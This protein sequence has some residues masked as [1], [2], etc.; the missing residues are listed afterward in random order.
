VQIPPSSAVALTVGSNTFGACID[1]TGGVS[2]VVALAGGT[3]LFTGF[4]GGGGGGGGAGGAVNILDFGGTNEAAVNASHQLAIQAPP[5]LPLPSNAAQET[6]GNLATV[7]TNTGTTATNTTTTNTDLGPPGATA[8]TT[9]TAS[10]SINQQMQRLAQRLSTLITA[11][12]SPVQAGTVP[13]SAADGQLATI[14]NK[15]DAKSS[16]TDGTSISVQQVLKE[17]SF[18]LQNP[19]VVT[20]TFWQTT[21]PVSGTVTANLGTLNG[22]ATAANQSSVI[23]SSTG[24]T[25]AASSSLAGAI[26]NSSPPSLTTGQ[27]VGLQTDSAGRLIVNVAAGGGTGGTSSNFASAFPS[28]G[29][30]IGAKNGAN[31]VN[32]TADSS[33]NL[34]VNCTVGCAGGTFNNNADGVATSTTNGQSAGWNYVFNGTTWDRLRGDTTNGLFADVKTIAT[35]AAVSGAFVDGAIATIGTKADAAWT[36]GAGSEIS[37]L[38]TIAAGVINTIDEGAF[39]FGTTVNL[40]AACVFQTTPTS[41]ALTTGQMGAVQ[42]TSNR[43]LFTNAY[44]WAGGVL[45]AMANYGTSPGAVLVPGVNA[46]VTNTIAATVSGVSTAANQPSN[47]AIG[48]TTSGQTGNLEMGAVTTAAPTYTTAQTNPLSLTT[49]GGLRT[50]ESTVAGTTISTGAGATGTGTQRVGIAQ[51]TTTIAGSAPGT[52]GSAS[53][54]VVT[55][56]GIASMTALK[57]DGSGVTQPVSGTVTVT[58]ATGTNL[59]TV[60]DSGC[61][62]SSAP[63]DESAFTAGTTSQTPVGG[64]F[65]TTATSNPLT[66]GQMGAFQ[67]TANRALFSNLR[68]AAGTEVGTAATPL[69]VSLA[70]TGTNAT[71]VLTTATGPAASG[72]AKS[73]GPVQI[74]SVFNT[75]QPTVTNGQIVEGQATARGGLIVATGVD[76]FAVSGAAASGASK[77]GNPVQIGGVFNTTQPTVTSGQAVEAQST[78]RGAQIVAPGVDGFAVTVSGVATATNQTNTQGTVAAGTAAANS[79]L[80]GCVYNSTFP[81]PTTGQGLAVQCNNIGALSAAIG[82]NTTGVL[83]PVPES[84]GS[85]A[86]SISTAT[87]TQLVA[88][89]S[90]KAIYVTAWDVIAAGTGN[91]QLEYGTGSNCGTGT[92][93]LTGNY[94]LT[95]QAGISKGSGFGAILF[96]PASNALCAVTS[97]AVGMAGS[98]SYAQY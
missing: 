74:G 48:S 4:G 1:Q 51:D 21:Q 17:I 15:A 49:A 9:D 30:A 54:N 88:L 94:N 77:A 96:I 47:A 7:V 13:V 39:T 92:T 5:T 97:A 65:Q 36:S 50:D 89:S 59:H 86:I 62:S 11:V 66:T 61:S 16:A 93:A 63:A 60:C 46:F 20:G 52:A 19:I 64:F 27:Q 87:T 95:A 58:Q 2:N 35:G 80:A 8:C 84:G 78:A 18:L 68:N 90:G 76:A 98:L 23:G 71:A 85:V 22:A 57:V 24:G 70:N 28:I 83:S 40:P 12:G 34:N 53:A 6:G 41:N 33:S 55:V 79:T 73:G 31:M 42:C 14:G 91:I 82:Q 38:K 56:Q 45:G 26:Y 81:T 43:S 29:T 25:A 69:Q 32:L 75:T 10:C 3:G 67:V 37:L 44:Q 72:V